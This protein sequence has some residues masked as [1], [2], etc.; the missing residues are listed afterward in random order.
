MHKMEEA[1]SVVS[2]LG[3]CGAV[4][5]VLF[6]APQIPEGVTGLRRSGTGLC[7][8][9][10]GLRWSGTGLRRSDWTPQE[11]DWNLQE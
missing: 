3:G 6:S 10:T 5:A 2:Q 11:W 1:N 4:D 8:S 9:G 7:R